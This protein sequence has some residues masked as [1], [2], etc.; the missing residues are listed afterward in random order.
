L[1]TEARPDWKIDD[2]RP[3]FEHVIECFGPQRIVWGSDWPVMT[4]NADYGQWLYAAQELIAPL[5]ESDRV[6]VMGLN[7]ARF[8]RLQTARSI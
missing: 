4:L 7:A 6:A 2:L 8:Y 1:V 5:S 3:Y